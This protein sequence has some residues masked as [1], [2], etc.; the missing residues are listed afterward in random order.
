VLQQGLDH[1][2]VHQVHD[3]PGFNALAGA[4]PLRRV[5][6]ERAGER[7]QPAPQQPLLAASQVPA[8]VDRRT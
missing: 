2:P 1:Q 7:R 6:R 3:V 5:Q 4:H 8:P